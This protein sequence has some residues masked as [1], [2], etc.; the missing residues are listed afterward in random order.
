[1]IVD[2]LKSL[3]KL[4]CLSLSFLFEVNADIMDIGA[5][6]SQNK[7]IEGKGMMDE[8]KKY[9]RNKKH[10]TI[11][12]QHILFRSIHSLNRFEIHFTV[13]MESF[14][15]SIHAVFPCALCN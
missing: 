9:E 14:D 6:P 5:S 13:K 12:Y 11:R 1:M 8:H 7:V 4:V 10:H 15:F 3:T 2:L